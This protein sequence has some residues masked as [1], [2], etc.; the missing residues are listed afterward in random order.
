MDDAVFLIALRDRLGA[1]SQHV[2]MHER[3][4]L[5]QQFAMFPKLAERRNQIA[6]IG[7]YSPTPW[8]CRRTID[9]AAPESVKSR[10]LSGAG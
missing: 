5:E 1:Y 10:C 7:S 2:R 8:G 6:S 3:E 4:Q 9:N